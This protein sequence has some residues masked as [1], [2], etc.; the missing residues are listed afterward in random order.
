MCQPLFQPIGVEIPNS[1]LSIFICVA[2]LTGQKY[3]GGLG[4]VCGVIPKEVMVL[5]TANDQG[6]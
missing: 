5:D 2:V 3:T 1:M 6:S 4:R